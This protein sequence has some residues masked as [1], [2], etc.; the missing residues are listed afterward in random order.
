MNRVFRN[1]AGGV[2]IGYLGAAKGF[3]PCVVGVN[4]IY[5]NGGPGLVKRWEMQQQHC[6]NDDQSNCQ[7]PNYFQRAKRQDNEIYNNKE[8]TNVSKFN[9]SVPYCSNCRKSCESN[10]CGKSWV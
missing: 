2:C 7:A 10:R 6:T 3:S 8:S 1:K 4:E 5:D 9:I